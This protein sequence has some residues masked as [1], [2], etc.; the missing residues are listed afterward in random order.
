MSTFLAS[1]VVICVIFFT[2]VLYTF[3]RYTR[4]IAY[5]A[6]NV[7]Q[8]RKNAR[9]K[10]TSLKG[11]EVILTTSDGMELQA[12]FVSSPQETHRLIVFCHQTASDLHSWQRYAG[13]LPAEGFDVLT[14]NFRSFSKDHFYQWPTQGE[15]KDVLTA[16]RWGRKRKEDYSIGLFGIS[17]GSVAA[18]AA[19]SQD[20]GVRAVLADGFF[21]TTRTLEAF[22]KRWVSIYV[23]QTI[24]TDHL[25]YWLYQ[26]LARSS[27]AYAGLR[28][29]CDFFSS[30]KY[31]KCL[32]SPVFFIHAER[33]EYIRE[34]QM[35]ELSRL[36]NS[37]R[38]LWIVPEASHTEGIDQNPSLYRDKAVEFFS[39]YL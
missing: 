19:A 32:A 9:P 4:L 21:S 6:L 16:I 7:P 14:F 22:M 30:E 17:K 28:N 18:V 27:L 2:Y 29:Q 38:G 10:D 24:I 3:V 36:T 35:K 33:D 34:D 11:Q 39:R 12:Q 25:P 20:K 13:Y 5:N 1:F 8:L 31:L 23:R 26:A 15:V 37:C